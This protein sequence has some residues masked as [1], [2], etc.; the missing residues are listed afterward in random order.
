MLHTAKLSRS[1]F[2]GMFLAFLLVASPVSAQTAEEQYRSTLLSLIAVLQEQI[3]SLQQEIEN[4]RAAESNNILIDIDGEAVAVYQVYDQ[5][6]SASA[7][8]AH[9][10]YLD[11]LYRIMPDQYDDAIDEFVV[12]RSDSDDVGAYVETTIPYTNDWR[13]GVSEDEVQEDPESDASIELMV[14]EF[15]HIFSFDQVFTLN[16]FDSDCHSYFEDDLCYRKGTYLGDFIAEF[17][18]Y[19]M[20]TDLE[21]VK[22]GVGLTQAEFYEQYAD[23]FVSDYAATDPAEDFAESF[24]WYAY[25]RIA[26]RGSVADMKIEFFD[27]YPYVQDLA[28]D[29]ESEL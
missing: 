26:P 5:E 4:K 16:Q 15:A 10:Q 27:R 19:Q 24:V 21:S 13:Y 18:N 11:Q 20:L 1:I 8:L 12:F 23:Q 14:H 9:Q 3:Q 28:K 25:G 2:V 17:W 22:E 7:D 29:I 6:I